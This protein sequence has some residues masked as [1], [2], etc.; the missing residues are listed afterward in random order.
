[1]TFADLPTTDRSGRDLQVENARIESVSIDNENHGCLTAWVH[2]RWRSSGCGFGGYKLGHADRPNVAAKAGDKDYCA[3]FI[4][5]CIN[6][7]NDDGSGRWEKL[8]GKPVRILH[9]G[10]GGG[11]VAIGHLFDDKWFCPQVEFSSK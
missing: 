10:L 6:V 4:R 7:V 1:M 11:V 5:L 9:E 8:V 2:L 3:E